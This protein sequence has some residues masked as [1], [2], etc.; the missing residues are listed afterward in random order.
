VL[1]AEDNPVN[2]AVASRHARIARV[3][4]S[5]AE[6]GRVAIERLSQESFDLVL[7]DCQMPEMDGFAGDPG[8]PFAAAAG[9]A[10]PP[11][12]RSSH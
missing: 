9:P 6:N 5:L 11:S 4:C 1:I 12:C 8:D 10:A 2:Q 3:T 7:M